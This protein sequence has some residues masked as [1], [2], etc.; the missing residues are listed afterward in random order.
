MNQICIG[1]FVI[2][3]LFNGDFANT[4]YRKGEEV[5][6]NCDPKPGVITF[7]FQ[8]NRSG[9]K[10]L[11]TVKST[12]VKGN[13]NQTKY[14]VNK[15]G[16]GSLAIQSFDKK[17]DSGFYTCAAM[18]NNKLIFG[19]LTEINGEPD[20]TTPPP[21]IAPLSTKFAPTPPMATTKSQCKCSEQVKPSINC[22]IW[23]LS[24]LASGCVLLLILL[25]IT[26]FYCNHPDLLAMQN[27]PTTSSS[28]S[29]DTGKSSTG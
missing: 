22:A 16:K 3:S 1:F 18:N 17:T 7:W 23:I 20:P 28:S 14:K 10:Y 26:I 5:P 25:I 2:L 24:S 13:V 29:I 21:K 11:F 15:S 9:A 27:C 12:D 19:E 8:I 4:I 6:I